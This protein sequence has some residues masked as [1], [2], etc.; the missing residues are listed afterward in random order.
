MPPAAGLRHPQAKTQPT[1][2]KHQPKLCS[3]DPSQIPVPT[4]KPLRPELP[5]QLRRADGGKTP[6]AAGSTRTAAAPGPV[7]PEGAASSAKKE[8]RAGTEPA[9]VFRRLD[10]GYGRGGGDGLGVLRELGLSEGGLVSDDLLLLLGGVHDDNIGEGLPGA[11]L[12]RGVVVLHDPHLH[13]RKRM[14]SEF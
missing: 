9:P 6:A 7:P 5:W 4:Q 8:I 12:A 11:G 1:S 13:T 2:S 3:T 10:S 14:V